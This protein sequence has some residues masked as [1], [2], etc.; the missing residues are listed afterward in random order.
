[1]LKQAASH[2]THRIARGGDSKITP[3]PTDLESGVESM[4]SSQSATQ[5][6]PQFDWQRDRCHPRSFLE[7]SFSF[8]TFNIFQHACSAG[9][10]IALGPGQYE[11]C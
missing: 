9:N 6:S 10:G 8:N 4:G 2:L 1:M 11:S 5:H 3:L 7:A